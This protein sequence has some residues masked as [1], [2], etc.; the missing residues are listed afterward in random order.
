LTNNF[1]SGNANTFYDLSND[2]INYV[3]FDNTMLTLGYGQEEFDKDGLKLYTYDPI[4]YKYE[5]SAQERLKLIHSRFIKFNTEDSKYHAYEENDNGEMVEA[6]TREPLFDE[7]TD[8]MTL[9]YKESAGKYSDYL[10]KHNYLRLGFSPLV[11]GD[12]KTY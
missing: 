8:F 12:E 10:G 4:E 6:I 1:K 3:S 11:L 2:P 9:W 5:Q 7:N